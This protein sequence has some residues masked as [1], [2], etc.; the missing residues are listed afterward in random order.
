MPAITPAQSSPPRIT[1]LRPE[2]EGASTSEIVPAQR[3]PQFSGPEG[4]RARSRTGVEASPLRT[5]DSQAPLL[6]TRPTPSS[7][8]SDRVVAGQLQGVVMASLGVRELSPD[9]EA[10][11]VENA[12]VLRGKGFDTA[13]KV[14]GLLKSAWRH[15]SILA[16]GALGLTGSAGYAIGMELASEKLVAKLPGHILRNPSAMGMVVG[17]G[18]GVLDVAISVMGQATVKPLIYNGAEGNALLPPSIEVPRGAEAIMDSIKLATSANFLKNLPRLPA[19]GLQAFAERHLHGVQ[20]GSILRRTADRI[21]VGLDAGLGIAASAAVQFKN[22]T[23]ATGY[24]AR[25][26]LRSDLGGVIDKMQGSYKDSLANVARSVGSAL[27]QPAVPLAVV[28]TV[29]VFISEL[30]AANAMID[31]AGHA[32]AGS[33]GALPADRADWSVMTG[34]RAS[35]VALMALM[36]ATIEFGAPIVAAGA[37]R[38]SGAATGAAKA[39]AGKVSDATM[40]AIAFV[41]ESAGRL[42]NIGAWVTQ[43]LGLHSGEASHADIEMGPAPHHSVRIEE[44]PT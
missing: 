13:E 38:L 29:G 14:E 23:G 43:R 32:A 34:K 35:S 8:L 19:P 2:T 27:T 44:L 37:D 20:D 41:G 28:A 22:L 5:P 6:S 11:L 12:G 36:T 10:R 26:L 30:F 40:S 39:A 24:D 16:V 9:V 1:S 18:V 15:D 3:S 42:P 4:L 7:P 33:H 17:L 21:D 31:S 25:M